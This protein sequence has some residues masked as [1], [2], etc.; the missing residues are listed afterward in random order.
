MICILSTL[1]DQVRTFTP[2]LFRNF[3][4][5]S[6]ALLSAVSSG[7]LQW[8]SEAESQ[9]ADIATEYTSIR[10]LEYTNTLDRY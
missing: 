9:E 4:S 5:I 6:P 7:V 2:P 3:L 8:K 10:V 1:I